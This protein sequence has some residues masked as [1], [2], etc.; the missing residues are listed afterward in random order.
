MSEIPEKYERFL[1]EQGNRFLLIFDEELMSHDDDF[2]EDYCYTNY[3]EGGNLFFDK[4][5]YKEFT[6]YIDGKCRYEVSSI[7]ISKIISRLNKIEKKIDVLSS[8]FR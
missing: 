4:E 8:K 1:E 7:D 2:I 5:H 3:S 6:N